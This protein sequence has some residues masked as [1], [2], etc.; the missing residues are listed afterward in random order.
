MLAGSSIG[1]IP[2]YAPERQDYSPSTLQR[3]ETAWPDN[4]QTFLTP[5]SCCTKYDVKP[6]KTHEWNISIQKSVPFNSAVT[7]SY[8]G[9]RGVDLITANNS[10]NE[11]PPGPYA[12]FQASRPYPRIS[13]IQIFDN[14]GSQSYHGML[15]K[16]ERRFAEG[17]ASTVSYSFGKSIDENGS[18]WQDIPTPFGP[19]GYNRGRN[20]QDRAHL[21][22]I[23][24]VWELPFGRHRKYLTDLHPV[25]NGI[26]G[27]W[28]LSGFYFFNSGTPLT[29]TVPGATLGNTWDTRPNLAA[30]PRL[31]NP[32]ADRW[33]NPDAFQR[34][35]LYTF[36]N[37]GIGIMDGPGSHN[38]DLGLMKNFYF[39]ENKYLQF[40]WELFNL[41]NHVNLAN[42]TTTIGIGTTGRILSAGPARS[43]QFGLKVVF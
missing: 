1:S 13:V 31:P 28:Q 2:F 37:S 18:S 23:S 42:P 40:R 22:T 21:L 33:F 5:F 19:D 39:T 24:N 14:I 9:S 35:P 6:Q 16:W 20:S 7:V 3:W 30:D 36:G 12:N 41:P 38:L 32:T 25:V 17:L 10:L 34:P 43:M 15:L 8:V 26:L 29:F 4:P 27:G 11:L